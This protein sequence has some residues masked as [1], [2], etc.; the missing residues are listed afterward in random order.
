MLFSK[1]KY[2]FSYFV[3]IIV[4]VVNNPLRLSVCVSFTFRGLRSDLFYILILFIFFYIFFLA[5][6]FVRFFVGSFEA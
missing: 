2:L 4:V 3:I 1:N 5:Y 6:K